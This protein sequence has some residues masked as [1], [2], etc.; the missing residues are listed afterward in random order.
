MLLAH[1]RGLLKPN[2]PNGIYSCIREELV[3]QA[4]SQETEGKHLHQQALMSTSMM[5]VIDVKDRQRSLR[6]AMD[7]LRMGTALLR[8]ESYAKLVRQFKAHSLEANIAALRM[9]EH[10]NVF[11][12]LETRLKQETKEP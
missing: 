1:L 3:L 11:D 9:L 8:M 7:N 6:S 4:I 12:I 5:D 2:Y 10:T